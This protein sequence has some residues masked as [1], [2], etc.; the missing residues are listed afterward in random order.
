MNE[1]CVPG[2]SWITGKIVPVGQAVDGS[3]MVWSCK[4]TIILGR[5]IFS[6][7]TLSFTTCLV[8][9][10]HFLL[11]LMGQIYPIPNG[12]CLN[13]PM[14]TFNLFSN[15][16]QVHFRAACSKIQALTCH[17]EISLR[18]VTWIKWYKPYVSG[19]RLFFCLGLTLWHLIK[20]LIQKNGEVHLSDFSL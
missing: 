1:I 12:E 16:L 9:Q 10:P 11:D 6:W 14:P 4:F 18:G 8:L 17:W 13:I 2:N 5:N 20:I 19:N 15:Y 3:L 7:L